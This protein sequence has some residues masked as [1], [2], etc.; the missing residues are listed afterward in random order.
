MPWRQ[1]LLSQSRY[2][3]RDL[4]WKWPSHLV[5]YTILGP[6]GPGDRHIPSPACS[7]LPVTLPARSRALITHYLQPHLVLHVL[8]SQKGR[9]K[10][11]QRQRFTTV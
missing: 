2:R 4:L 1:V 10:R 11:N 9:G 8:A 6:Q 3:N 7:L 5:F